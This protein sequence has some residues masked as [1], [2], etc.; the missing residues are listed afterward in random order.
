MDEN[1]QQ[2]L[3]QIAAKILSGGLA[4]AES[5]PYHQYNPEQLDFIMTEIDRQLLE[6]AKNILKTYDEE[7][8]EGTR[9][10]TGHP[11]D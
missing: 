9:T 11:L 8:H 10:A 5:F 2:K 6:D 3:K 4:A 1:E 7:T